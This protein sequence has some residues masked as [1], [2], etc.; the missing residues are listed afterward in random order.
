MIDHSQ[1]VVID[2]DARNQFARLLPEIDRHVR[3][4]FRHLDPEL[5]EDRTA[6]AVAL[7]FEMFVGLVRHQRGKDAFPTPLA[8]FAVRQVSEGRQCGTSQNRHDVTSRY[9]QHLTGVQVLS[10]H[11][12]E[13]HSDRWQEWVVEDRSAGPADVASTRIDFRD[14]LSTL[15]HKNRQIAELLAAGETT[16]TVAQQFQLT[17]GRISQ[18]RRELLRAWNE[19]QE[20]VPTAV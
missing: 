14:W 12:N 6:D 19:F 20:L 2:E 10:L 5:C 16:Q 1:D 13:R 9:C 7:A 18:V 17:A 3:F 11:R 4:R 8:D 15:S